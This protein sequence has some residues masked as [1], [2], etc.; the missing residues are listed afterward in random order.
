MRKYSV[1]C[2]CPVFW[3]EHPG[4]HNGCGFES[5]GRILCYGSGRT[6]I[7]LLDCHHSPVVPASAEKLKADPAMFPCPGPWDPPTATSLVK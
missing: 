1:Q 7:P 5:T 2:Q 6:N 4:N 3:R